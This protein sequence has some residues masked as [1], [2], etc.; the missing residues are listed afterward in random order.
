MIFLHHDDSVW[1]HGV[2]V[3]FPIKEKELLY[4]RALQNSLLAL[5]TPLYEVSITSNGERFLVGL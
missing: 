2:G 5:V 1:K 4:G 3:S